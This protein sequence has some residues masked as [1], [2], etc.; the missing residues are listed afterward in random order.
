[1]PQRR[2]QVET[3]HTFVNQFVGILTLGIYTPMQIR[4]TCAA[5]ESASA[6]P[7]APLVTARGTSATAR[8][9][10]FTKAVTQ[11][12]ASRKSVYLQF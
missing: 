5:R 1:M 2:G 11:A 4:V 9:E 3:Q 10:A 12:A 7:A 6:D 8:Q